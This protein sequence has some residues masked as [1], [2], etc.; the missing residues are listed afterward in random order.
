MR[1]CTRIHLG[2]IHSRPRLLREKV[3]KSFMST[4]S[5]KVAW[6]WYAAR[7][8]F[9]KSRNLTKD[10]GNFRFSGVHGTWKLKKSKEKVT[11]LVIGTVWNLTFSSFRNTKLQNLFHLAFCENQFWLSF[12]KQILASKSY[13]NENFPLEDRFFVK[14]RNRSY[15]FLHVAWHY[16]IEK[17]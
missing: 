4:S 14:L 15:P 11:E 7:M 2:K 6:F 9:G 17:L 5:C 3:T 8:N 12:I 16:N 1:L 13:R 10:W